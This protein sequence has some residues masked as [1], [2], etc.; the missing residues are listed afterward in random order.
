MGPKKYLASGVSAVT[1]Q[2]ASVFF[3]EGVD[4]FQ[5]TV[6]AYLSDRNGSLFWVG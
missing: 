4:A 2:Q 6:D 5:N 1:T 3:K